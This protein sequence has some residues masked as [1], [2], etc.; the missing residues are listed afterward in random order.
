MTGTIYH[1]TEGTVAYTASQYGGTP[2][3]ASTSDS[4]PMED[5][6][7]AQFPWVAELPSDERTQFAS[8]FRDAMV[9]WVESRAAADYHGMADI[10]EDWRA[11]VESRQNVG[12]QRALAR[13][14]RAP[15][16]WE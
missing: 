6:L 10:V 12:L 4:L 11:T 15:V 9:R 1:P 7:L 3:K 5:I 8:E 13:T 2:Q 16:P 14:D